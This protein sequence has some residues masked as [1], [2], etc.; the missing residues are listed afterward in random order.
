VTVLVTGAAGFI[1]SRVVAAL[2]ARGTTVRA[3]VRSPA[4]VPAPDSAEGIE[5]VHGDLLRADLR[6]ALGGVD[7]VVHLAAKV[8]GSD[9]QRFAAAVTGTDRLLAAMARSSVRRLVL[10]STFAVYDWSRVHARLD[11]RSPLVG[12]GLYERDGYTIAK[13]WQERIAR[14]ASAEE[15]FELTVLRPGFVWG[16]GGEW[17]PGSGQRVGPVAVVVA[18]RARL[19]LTYVENC[20]DCF[21]VA[22][23]H[24]AAAGRTFNVVD[25]GRVRSWR[26][27]G[28]YL[29]G[30]GLGGV[31]V[32]VPYVAAHVCVRAAHVAVQRAAGGRAR[33]P[34]VAVPCRFEARFKPV[35]HSGEE[36]AR[37]LGW[38]P[39]VPFEEALRR[40][41]GER[42]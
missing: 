24:P 32:P 12:P 5:V 38:R 14:R 37:V 13:A 18:P 28:E 33:L 36:L 10:A 8:L 25:D 9:E 1:G 42:G 40:T 31:R 21:A 23:A 2:A 20:A 29:R 16:R 7:T 35:R 19:P 17:V 27:M 6:E 15:G 4:A 39:P 34:S 26:Y 22:A 3:L 30:T 11:E 41:Y